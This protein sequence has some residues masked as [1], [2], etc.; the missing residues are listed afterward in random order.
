MKVFSLLKKKQKKN[1]R[2]SAVEHFAATYSKLLNLR[3]GAST[4]GCGA[5]PVYLNPDI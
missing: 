3:R 5:L 2:V 1:N 4:P